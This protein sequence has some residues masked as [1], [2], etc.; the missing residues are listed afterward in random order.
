MS[1]RVDYGV[2]LEDMSMGPNTNGPS[3]GDGRLHVVFTIMY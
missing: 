1:L 3:A 2:I